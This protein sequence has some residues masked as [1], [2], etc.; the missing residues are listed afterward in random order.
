MAHPDFVHIG[1]RQRDTHLNRGRIFA[2]RADLA[3]DVPRGLL[4]LSEQRIQRWG[5]S[6]ADDCALRDGSRS[7]RQLEKIAVP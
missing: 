6:A 2:P 3:A 4:D 7:K 1:E 5:I